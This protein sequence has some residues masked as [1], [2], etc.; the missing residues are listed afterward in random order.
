MLERTVV[1]RTISRVTWVSTMVTWARAA[2]GNSQTLYSRQRARTSR[3][4]G[5]GEMV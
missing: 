3:I 4:A 1:L 5:M 2:V